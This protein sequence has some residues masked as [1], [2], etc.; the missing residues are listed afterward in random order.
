MA[1]ILNLYF[2]CVT[3]PALEPA[4]IQAEQYLLYDPNLNPYFSCVT[5]PALEPADVQA[6]QCTVNLDKPEC[7]PVC[8][9]FVYI[10]CKGI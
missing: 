1:L 3:L 8:S 7:K 10:N 2:S 9:H 5:L 4:D 6:E